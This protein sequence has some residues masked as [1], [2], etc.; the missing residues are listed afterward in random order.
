MGDDGRRNER[1][2]RVGVLALQGS[3]REHA[4]CLARLGT[5]PVF[6]R[7]RRQ[8]ADLCGLIIPGGESTTIR[9]LLG[10]YG[11]VEPI[12]TLSRCGLCRGSGKFPT[13][14][15]VRVTKIPHY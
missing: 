2:M 7:R 12:R 4:E 8:L 13:M 6:V 10:R 11:L 15:A 14:R 9:R 3:F 1:L 5:E